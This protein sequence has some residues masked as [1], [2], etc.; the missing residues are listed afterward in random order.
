VTG[1]PIKFEETDHRSIKRRMGLAPMEGVTDFATRLWFQI[2]GGMDF[3]WTPFLRVTDTFPLK[4]TPDFAPELDELKG[5]FRAPLILQVMGSKPEDII[6]T[7]DLYGD[8]IEFID[9]NC[10]CPSP[11][12]VGSRA[13]SSLLERR[14]FFENFIT[15]VC[16]R[17][18]AQ[19]LSVKMRTGFHDASEFPDLLSCIADLPL[20]HLTVH[21]RTRPQKYKGF[22][23]WDLIR[24]AASRC[25]YAVVGS[26]DLSSLSAVHEVSQTSK[27]VSGFIIGRGALRNPWIFSGD[28]AAPVLM[29]FV[30]FVLLQD[31]QLERFAGVVDFAYKN[32]MRFP[33]G[34]NQDVWSE[35]LELI[36]KERGKTGENWRTSEV[37]PRALSRGKM[38]WNY[39][40]TSLPEP[41]MD[42]TL[43]RVKTLATMIEAIEIIA[44]NHHFDIASLPITHQSHHD[45]MFS[46]EG[47]KPI[48][49]SS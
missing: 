11:T 31:L 18:G 34:I 40:R 21:G 16:R 5:A 23:D 39:L 45:W 30:A 33:A 32:A 24:L 36:S 12:V 41:F 14:E 2:V 7:H 47:K 43:M 38:L 44:R 4:Y 1:F 35:I 15:F 20:R 28:S 27:N 42:P 6:R 46:G 19:R 26:G 9:L 25:G 48:S 17:V 8:R 29:A 22:A 10:G 13:G 37:S 49:E 3:T